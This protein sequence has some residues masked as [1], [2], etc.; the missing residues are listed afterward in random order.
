MR[1]RFIVLEGGD[2]AGKTTL[3]RA[4]TAALAEA[5]RAVVATR[6][7]GGTRAGMALRTLL[8]AEDGPGFTPDA[9]LLLM[10]AA[11]VQHVREIIEPALARGAMVVCD[12]FIGSTLAYQ[13]HGSGLDAARILALHRD[14][15]GDLWPD[16]TL[17]LDLP[18]DLA[19]ARG[20]ARLAASAANEGRFEARD[21]AF[22]AR[23][24]DGFLALARTLPGWTVLDA[25]LAPA[26]LL[27]AARASLGA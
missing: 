21:M 18:P 27:A 16:A 8:L 13:G 17:L 2:G 6:E 3:A 10:T 19:L 1:G 23:V 9:E 12:R 25:T 22:H 4:L 15:V 7:P 5:G 14:F 26:A 11:R 20:R 24:R